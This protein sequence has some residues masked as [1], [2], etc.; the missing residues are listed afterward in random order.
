MFTAIDNIGNG[1]KFV[2][3]TGRVERRWHY[4]PDAA[5]ETSGG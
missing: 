3:L 2:L 4:L 1:E 5:K